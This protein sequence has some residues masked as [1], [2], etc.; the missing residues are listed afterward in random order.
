MKISRYAS[1][2]S[3]TIGILG[4]SIGHSAEAATIVG[5][6]SRIDIP[7]INV[8]AR[9]EEQGLTRARVMA[10]P[11]SMRNVAWYNRG[12]RPGTKGNGILYGHLDDRRFK[13]AV[14]ANLKKLKVGDVVKVTDDRGT[15][16]VFTV[17]KTK[18]YTLEELPTESIL[19]KSKQANVVLYTCAGTWSKKLGRYTKWLVVYATQTD[20]YPVKKI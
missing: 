10:L 12:V 4:V 17:S 18:T 16:R 3:I 2:I 13:P 20:A 8:H 11:R 1:L 14:F 9:I 6:P 5:R 7:K 15:V 19:G